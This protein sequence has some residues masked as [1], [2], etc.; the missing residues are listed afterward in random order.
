MTNQIRKLL[1]IKDFVDSPAGERWYAGCSFGEF[2]K[3]VIPAIK[4]YDKEM[5]NR[6]KDWQ[7]DL[8]THT[9]DEGL[10]TPKKSS[11]KKSAATD[12][13]IAKNPQNPYPVYLMFKKSDTFT[14]DQLFSALESLNR[15][16]L[17][18]KTSAQDKKLILEEAILK[19]CR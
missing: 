4:K 8:S 1:L 5:L 13:V 2:K 16:D 17:R 3:S 7:V 14:A 18:I 19:I 9:G 15:A 6:I 12:L 10:K 11:K